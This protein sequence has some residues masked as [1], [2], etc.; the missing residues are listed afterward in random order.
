MFVDF[1]IRRPVLASVLAMLTVIGGAIAIPALPIARY[2][3]LAAPQ[4]VVTANYIGAS[5][6]IVEAAVTTPLEVSINGAE[7][8]RYIQSASTND[9]ISTVTVTF[10]PERDI[11]LAAVDVQNRVQT[12]LPRLPV[13]VRNTGVTVTKSST[14]IVLAAAFFARQG[15]Y[16]QE[17]ISNYIDR[18]VRDELLRVPGVGEARIFNP[19]TYAMRLWLDPDK[20]AARGLTAGDVT[21]ALREQNLEIAAGALGRE[22]AVAGQALQI[23]VRAAGRLPDADAFARI[24]LKTGNDGTLVQVKDVGRVDLGAEDYGSILRFNGREAI[25]IG[26]FQLPSAN[27]LDVEKGCRAV[28]AELAKRFPP[29]LHYEIGFNPT[30]AVRESISEVVRTLVEAIV[31]VI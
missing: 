8:M 21:G 30:E 20:L 27:A 9:G 25:G 16:S 23:S 24:V 7:G 2:P 14:S 10:N 31:I 29:G 18:Y 6:Q 12:A 17:F 22:P 5:S 13:D 15:E 3:Q 26:I 1:F 4:V 19:R 28:L 11:D